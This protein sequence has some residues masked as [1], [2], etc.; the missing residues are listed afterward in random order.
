VIGRHGGQCASIF[1]VVIRGLDP[2]I[3]QASQSVF[4]KKMD[5]RVKL[6]DDGLYFAKHDSF[7]RYK[8]A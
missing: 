5:G 8:P 7:L 3:H 6:G 4:S 2:R 1:S